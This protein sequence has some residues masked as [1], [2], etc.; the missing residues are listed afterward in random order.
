MKLDKCLE[1]LFHN[2]YKNGQVLCNFNN[3]IVSMVTYSDEK[4]AIVYVI[5]CPLDK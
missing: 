3:I 2:N 5:G 1:C 4:T